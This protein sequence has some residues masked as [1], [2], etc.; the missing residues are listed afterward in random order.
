[1][2]CTATGGRAAVRLRGE[3]GAADL[4]G[5]VARRESLPLRPEADPVTLLHTPSVAA[6]GKA[7]DV[8]R[9]AA[10]VAHAAPRPG[11]DCVR[12]GAFEA[13]DLLLRLRAAHAVVADHSVVADHT[14]AGD[15]VRDRVVGERGADRA[16]RRRPSD[17]AGHPAVR[18][19]LAARDLRCLEQHVALERRQAAEVEPELADDVLGDRVDTLQLA[20]HP[21]SDPE[22]EVVGPAGSVDCRVA[23]GVESDQQAY[24]LA[25]D[26][27][28]SVS[29]HATPQGL[30]RAGVAQVARTGLY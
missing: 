10:V 2:T 18:P 23:A 12:V 24:H 3:G 6:G 25:I 8:R 4:A 28:V 20:L 19:H 30:C 11:L 22:L 14:V 16:D 21:A 7:E 5:P 17:L 9:V 27:R 26:L 1:M 13:Q 15:E 29:E